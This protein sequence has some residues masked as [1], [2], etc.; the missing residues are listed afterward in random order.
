MI[1]GFPSI[2]GAEILILLV[3]VLLF[4]GAKRI[5][6]LARSLGRGTREFR[7]GISGAGEDEVE[8]RD[9]EEKDRE[10]PLSGEAARDESSSAEAGTVHAEQKS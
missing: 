8:A 10:K 3:I 4:F 7:E 5:P 1:P 2:G 6:E 9:R